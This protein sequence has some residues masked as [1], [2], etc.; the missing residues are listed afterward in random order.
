MSKQ[1]KEVQNFS[2]FPCAAFGPSDDSIHQRGMSM[3]DW[4]AGMALQGMVS[5]PILPKVK[6]GDEEMTIGEWV[7]RNAYN[8]ADAMMEARVQNGD[9]S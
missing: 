9:I 8:M 5:Q 6:P 7:A 1:E 2:A 4:F 3:R